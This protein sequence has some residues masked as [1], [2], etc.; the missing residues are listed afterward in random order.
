MP[1]LSLDSI[2]AVA[3]RPRLWLTAAGAAMALAPDGWWRRRPFLPLPDE[4]VLRWR[5]TTAYGSSEGEVAP[6]DLVAYLEWRRRQR[7]AR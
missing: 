1:A 3:V 4:D 6:D 5:V 2:R 7:S